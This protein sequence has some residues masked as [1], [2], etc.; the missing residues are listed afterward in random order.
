MDDQF[1]I[2]SFKSSSE[3]GEEENKEGEAKFRYRLTLKTEKM[4]KCT[5]EKFGFT[6][7]L[8]DASAVRDRYKVI[9]KRDVFQ[10]FFSL[11]KF[12]GFSKLSKPKK[13]VNLTQ[14]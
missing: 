14:K 3:E 12:Q 1:A 7:E 11:L 8:T 10:K 9:L 4:M 13:C 6:G 2:L 5:V